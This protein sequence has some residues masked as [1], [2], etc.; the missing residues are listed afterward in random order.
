ML[1]ARGREKDKVRLI[2][3]GM[4]TLAVMTRQVHSTL[5]R[6]NDLKES[7][8][9][10]VGELPLPLLPV[11]KLKQGVKLVIIEVVHGVLIWARAVVAVLMR[12][13]KARK[14]ALESLASSP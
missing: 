4:G 8:Q 6:I 9:S 3:R 2:G 13:M 7:Q 5:V 14:R 1:Q 10:W 12:T 11:M